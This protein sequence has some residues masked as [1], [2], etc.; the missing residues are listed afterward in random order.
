MLSLQVS[1]VGL[2]LIR[3]EALG[4]ESI[5]ELVNTVEK[6]NGSMAV[7]RLTDGGSDQ[8]ADRRSWFLSSNTKQGRGACSS[9]QWQIQAIVKL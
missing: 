5:F 7:P 8:K 3:W 4:I 9:T 1:K 6:V 2:I